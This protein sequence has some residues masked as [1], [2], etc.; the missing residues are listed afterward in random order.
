MQMAMSSARTIGATVVA[1]LAIGLLLGGLS[2]SSLAQTQIQVFEFPAWFRDVDLGRA[3]QSPGD[4]R[5][6]VSD[7]LDPS[8]EEVLGRAIVRGTV[9]KSRGG[10][11]DV[12][13]ILDVT[14]QL[15]SGDIVFYGGLQVSELNSDTGA[16]L[17]VIGG[18]GDF[19]GAKG[20]V[21]IVSAEVAG[22]EGF[23]WTFDLIAG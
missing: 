11:D 10:G 18:T 4:L 1:S 6:G 23:M 8:D 15:G 21:T 5:L 13:F 19:A 20:T 7:L 9:V 3:G 2:P 16:V 12:T 22:Q 14:A 17:S